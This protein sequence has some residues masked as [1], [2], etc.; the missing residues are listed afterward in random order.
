VS[1]RKELAKA[2]S[3]TLTYMPAHHPKTSSFP[4]KVINQPI[5][6]RA[7]T[8]NLQVRINSRV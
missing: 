5:I 7:I 6:E 2:Y 3:T 4:S 1:V 8:G